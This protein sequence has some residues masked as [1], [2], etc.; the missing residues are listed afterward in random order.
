M[1]IL[2]VIYRDNRKIILGIHSQARS[3]FHL[4]ALSKTACKCRLH[5]WSR[6]HSFCKTAALAST[7]TSRAHGVG[8]VSTLYGDNSGSVDLIKNPIISERRMWFINCFRLWKNFYCSNEGNL[9]IGLLFVAIYSLCNQFD[10]FEGPLS[11]SLLWTNVLCSEG[12][13]A[14]FALPRF[15]L[16]PLS[17][18]LAIAVLVL[19]LFFSWGWLRDK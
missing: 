3:E 8:N 2:T 17:C 7:S 4:L 15:E 10:P 19:Y 12:W 16:Y 5:G 11:E 1:L 14:F 9:Y 6:I 13:N 18:L